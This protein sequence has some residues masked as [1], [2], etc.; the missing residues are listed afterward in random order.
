MKYPCPFTKCK[1]WSLAS[2]GIHIHQRSCKFNPLNRVESSQ[3]PRNSDFFTSLDKDQWTAEELNYALPHPYLNGTPCDSDGYDLPKGAAPNPPTPTDQEPWFPFG[4][5][6][7]FETADILFRRMKTS[8]GNINL[9]MEALSRFNKTDEPPFENYRDLNAKIDSIPHGDIPWQCFKGWFRDIRAVLEAQLADSNFDGSID[10]A[11]KDVRNKDGE[12]TFTDLMSGMWAWD[13]AD[14]LAQDPRNHGAMFAPVV[15]GS[16]KTTV[17]VATGKN[18][19]YP[20]YASLGNLQSHVRRAH[21]GS[22]A[23]VGFLAIP[24]AERK[25][26]DSELFRTFRRQLVHERVIWGIGPYIAD[27]PEQALLAC[28]VNVWCS[29]CTALPS[30]LDED[31][32]AAPRSHEHTSALFDASNNNAK[33]VWEGYGVISDVLPFTASFPRANIHELL[34]PDL[35]H[36]VIKGTFKD[37]LVDWISKYLEDLSPMAMTELDRR[38]SVVPPFPGLRRFTQGRRFKQWTGDDSKGLMKALLVPD[39]MVK[40]VAAFLDACYLARKAQLTASDIKSLE[41]AIDRFY[42]ERT[43]FI[44]EGIRS[45]ISLPRQHASKHYITLILLLGAP[46]GLCSSITE[47]K[48]I[49]AVKE[50][51]RR[52]SRHNAL[53]QMLRINQRLDKLAALQAH[54]QS[55]GCFPG[56]KMREGDKKLGLELTNDDD[57]KPVVDLTDGDDAEIV[58]GVSLVTQY[59]KSLARLATWFDMPSLIDHVRRYLYDHDN[60]DSNKIGME[61]DISLCPVIVADQVNVLVYNSAYCLVHSPGDPSGPDGMR[62]EYIRA[63]P[64]WRNSNPRHDCVLVDGDPTKDGFLGFEVGQVHFFFSF[65]LPGDETVHKCAFDHWFE[66][67][68]TE[69][70]PVTGLW[71]VRPQVSKKTERIV[72]VIRIDTIYSAAHLIG[73]TGEGPTPDNLTST[74]LRA[75]RSYFVNKYASAD[76]LDLLS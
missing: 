40:A 27:Y 32:S 37:H 44:Q 57:E 70:C 56:G 38:I 55:L 19:F 45:N 36:Q 54:L 68:D 21:V 8:N 50:P 17:S 33:K 46:L 41:A 59:P 2:R 25:D 65:R 26:D 75:Y 52:S 7:Q 30:Q 1:K 62:R 29:K 11:P 47:S 24:K 28:V 63:S 58:E 15:L 6:A 12:R 9:L 60:P 5:I 34:A 61:V 51:W 39:Q 69:P 35:L 31:D 64:N 18:E 23:V 71:K 14:E 4:N 73:D 22:V 72:S 67:D 20:L 74:A 16:D 10:Y 42:Q 13:Q 48:H 76:L 66:H 49:K 43:I 53:G 3:L